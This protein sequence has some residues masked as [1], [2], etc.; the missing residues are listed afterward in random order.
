MESA[1]AIRLAIA[2]AEVLAV[3]GGLD[4]AGMEIAKA[5]LEETPAQQ[6]ETPG[7]EGSSG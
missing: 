5:Q 3:Q 6:E 4:Q 7:P 2:K 1:A